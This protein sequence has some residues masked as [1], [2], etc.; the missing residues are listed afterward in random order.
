M[1]NITY[2]V[3]FRNNFFC[4][5]NSAN[6]SFNVDIII[7]ILLRLTPKSAF[8]DMQFRSYIFKIFYHFSPLDIGCWYIS[9]GNELKLIS[10]LVLPHL[11]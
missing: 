1:K 9:I 11:A 10:K 8:Y 5:Q 4:K 2:F 7:L 6:C 3:I